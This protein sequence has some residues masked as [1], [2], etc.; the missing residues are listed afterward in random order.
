MI[1]SLNDLWES[2]KLTVAGLM[3]GTSMDGIDVAITELSGNGSD[4]KW[5]VKYSNS[6]PFEND[7]R[8]QIQNS[9]DGGAE[10]IC[11]LNFDLG[12]EYSVSLGKA[13]TEAEIS[14]SE[15]DLIGSHGQT[16][17]HVDRHSS[18][19]VG[20]A[21]VLA[22]AFGVPVI[23][24]FR[25]RDIAAGGSGAPLVPYVDYILFGTDGGKL[26]LNLGGIA[27]FTA[28]PS[29]CNS[30]NDISAWDTGPANMLMDLAAGYITKGAQRFDTDGK[31]AASGEVNSSWLSKLLAHPYVSKPPPKSTGREDFGEKYFNSLLK[32]FEINSEASKLD[33]IATLTRFS[34]ESI[35]LNIN[36]YVKAEDGITE[37]I[38]SG[39]G[40]SNPVLMEHL[41][42]LFSP[43]KVTMIDDHGIKSD[44]IC[45][46]RERV[47]CR[48]S[49]KC[50]Q[51][52]RGIEARIIRKIN[53]LILGIMPK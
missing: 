15:L 48:N 34:A 49:I 17:Y 24:D 3:S 27:N 29:P 19:Q 45:Y 42:S 37:V 2:E 44:G 8:K 5:E 32:E 21:S 7:L 9:I 12:K 38:V 40:T 53:Y 20:E 46:S 18:L 43:I 35:K 28:I 14:S 26:L 50:S 11:R 23:S 16:I 31:F 52:N 1:K 10:A 51:S 13:L 36:K 41:V 4:T 33:L 47:Y 22:E 6:Y 25:V 30:L 39:G